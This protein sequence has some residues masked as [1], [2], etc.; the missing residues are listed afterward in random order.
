VTGQLLRQRPGRHLKQV[1]GR[2]SR[3]SKASIVQ[4]CQLG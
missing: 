4:W 1:R 2:P 3:A